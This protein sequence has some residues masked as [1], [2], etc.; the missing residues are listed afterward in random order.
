MGATAEIQPA[1]CQTPHGTIEHSCKSLHGPSSLATRK[2]LFSSAF[3]TQILHFSGHILFPSPLFTLDLEGRTALTGAL[4]NQK[5]KSLQENSK[6]PWIYRKWG[7]SEAA[8][9]QS[10]ERRS[11]PPDKDNEIPRQVALVPRNDEQS[12]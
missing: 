11:L 6:S 7:Q 9:E 8:G 12:T 2:A 5:Q 10:G 3:P 1:L 4:L